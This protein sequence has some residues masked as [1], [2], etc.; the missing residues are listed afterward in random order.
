MIEKT[1]INWTKKDKI[2]HFSDSI[3]SIKADLAWEIWYKKVWENYINTILFKSDK[4]VTQEDVLER[5]KLIE[6]S[7]VKYKK[8]KEDI[9]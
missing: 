2:R 3:Q 4:E 5:Q 1:D 7:L 6:E 9:H 8:L